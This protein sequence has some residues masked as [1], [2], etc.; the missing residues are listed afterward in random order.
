MHVKPR[1]SKC[2]Y[3]D[4]H[5]GKKVVRPDPFERA[6]THTSAFAHLSFYQ[7]DTR[8]PQSSFPCLRAFNLKCAHARIN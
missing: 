5:G 8:D 7:T 4:N 6:C 1:G 3:Y 2:T